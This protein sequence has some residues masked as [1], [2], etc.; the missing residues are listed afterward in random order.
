MC[1]G[2]QAA[3]Y[4]E[5]CPTVCRLLDS[6]EIFTAGLPRP[7]PA[8]EPP[9][10]QLLTASGLRALTLSRS[11]ITFFF[12]S[13]GGRRGCVPVIFFSAAEPGDLKLEPGDPKL[14]T[15]RVLELQQQEEDRAA[16]Q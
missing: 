8:A 1:H 3:H 2:V 15:P 14:V 6:V 16:P 5:V 7:P 9:A 4:N 10:L 11:Q 12:L 13:G